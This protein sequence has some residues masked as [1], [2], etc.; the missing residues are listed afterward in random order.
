MEGYFMNDLNTPKRFDA[1]VILGTVDESYRGIVGVIIKSYESEPFIIKAGTKIAQM[2]IEH[3][4]NESFEIVSEL[5]ETA[6]GEGGF[7][8]TGT[9]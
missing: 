4:C 5:S 1:D 7:G 3:Y 2:V 9:K 8:H 6:R